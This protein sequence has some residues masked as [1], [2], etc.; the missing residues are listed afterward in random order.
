LLL[1]CGGAAE[2][3]AW[4]VE[5]WR[6]REAGELAAVDIVPGARTVLI[7]G[8]EPGAADVIAGWPAPGEVERVDGPFVEVPTV[9]DG[10]DLPMVAE[11]WGVAVPEAIDRL[12]SAA[13]RVAFCGFAPGFPYLTGLP[14]QWLVP[15]LA[16]P[17]PRV[18]AGAVALAGGYAGIYPTASPGGWRLVGRTE[19]TLFDVHRDPPA[20]LVPGTR[21][22]LAAA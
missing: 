6:R 20:L 16:A 3:E 18:P 4:R 19:V 14:A 17:R 22:R 15:R 2:V 8:V 1:D 12:A 9:Y 11:H 5:C 21:V 10:V 13:L 7:D